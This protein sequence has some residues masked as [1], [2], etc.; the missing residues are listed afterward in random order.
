M[1]LLNALVREN[2]ATLVD[3]Q[4]LLVVVDSGNV[5]IH[6]DFVAAHRWFDAVSDLTA[7]VQP[8]PWSGKQDPVFVSPDPG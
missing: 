6:I 3:G 4:G 5:G 2:Q 7:E 1:G 8:A